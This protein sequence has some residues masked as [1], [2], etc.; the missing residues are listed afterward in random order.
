MARIRTIKPEL[1]A[2][3]TL[4]SVPLEARL[5]FIY[6][7]TQADDYGL[8]PGSNRQL[9][10]MLYPHD[11]SITEKKVDRW[12]NGLAD[13]GMVER[14]HTTDGATVVR[15]VNW[16]KHQRVDNRG[17]S[18]L[19]SKLVTNDSRI[20]A[21]DRGENPLGP[22][23]KEQDLGNGPRTR[24]SDWRE[25]FAVV[26]AAYPKKPNNPRAKAW[27]AYHA[28]R[29]EGVGAEPI[30]AGVMAYRDY[31]EREGTDPKFIKSA[32][33]FFGPDEHWTTD[34]SPTTRV[35]RG[36]TTESPGEALL[37]RAA[38]QDRAA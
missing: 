37:R 25:D 31:L 9:L 18:T 4:A 6:L 36:T 34:Y 15:I 27:K 22:R 5:T 24:E 28:R 30:L 23:T 19:W 38:A 29:K 13:A 2:D 33:T 16:D 3:R 1:P 12:I 11:D 10:G 17:H 21:E 8:V 35:P 20:V 26:W 32:A 7:I 14:C